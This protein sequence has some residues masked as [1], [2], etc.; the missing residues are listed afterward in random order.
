MQQRRSLWRVSRILVAVLPFLTSSGVCAQVSQSNRPDNVAGKDQSR[1]PKASAHTSV[2]EDDLPVKIFER[3]TT[4]SLEGSHLEADEGLVLETDDDDPAFTRELIRIQWRPGDPIDLYVVKPTRVTRPPV[5]LY[6]YGY[7]SEPRRFLDTDFCRS[8]TANGFAA[9]G[10]ASALTGQRYHD[11]PM[12]EWFVSELPE[13]L[14]TSA[15]DV[16]MILNYMDR[17]KDF[18]LSRVGIYGDGSGATIAILAAAVDPRIMSLDLVDPWG[19]WPNWIAA[20]PRIPEKERPAFLTPEFL[21]KVALLD[22]MKWLPELK[23]KSVRLQFVDTLT[24][25]SSRQLEAA[26]PRQAK[27]IDYPD[28]QSFLGAASHDKNFAWIKQ[29]LQPDFV[30]QYGVDEPAI[31][32]PGSQLSKR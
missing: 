20:S 13:A 17:R 23:T 15:H 29:Q 2:D 32:K 11:R 30:R 6:L 4:P 3:F 18:D 31:Q 24:P 9:V 1:A 14:A 16:Q 5:I 22:P 25:A 21:R 12:K 26:A 27:V 28:P 10:F 19:D 7:P 8:L